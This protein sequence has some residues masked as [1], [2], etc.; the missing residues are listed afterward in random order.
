M[1][2]SAWE[3][4]RIQGEIIYTPPPSPN[5]MFWPEGSFQGRGGGPRRGPWNASSDAHSALQ[6]KKGL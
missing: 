1:P 3:E 6:R 2:V 4:P 5:G